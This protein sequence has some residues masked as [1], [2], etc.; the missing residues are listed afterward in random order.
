MKK[1]F[2][3]SGI[4]LGIIILLVV[5]G[6]FLATKFIDLNAFKPT[7]TAQVKKMT[8]RTLTISGDIN[9]SLYPVLGID[10]KDATLSNLPAFGD[11]P[12]IKANDVRVGVRLIPLL[13]R[14]VEVERVVVNGLTINLI[15]NRQGAVNW[16]MPKA[17]VEETK[18]VSDKDKQPLTQQVTALKLIDMKNVTINWQNL[19]TGQKSKVDQLSIYAKNIQSGEFFPIKLSLNVNSNKPNVIGNINLS[20]KCKVSTFRK[21]YQLRDFV[22]TTKLRGKDVPQGKL[23]ARLK[24][25]V[26]ITGDEFKVSKLN[27]VMN[28]DTV[29]GNLDA[30]GVNKIA[31]FDPQS[32]LRPLNIK[33][34]LQSKRLRLAGMNLTNAKF[35]L[36]GQ[37]GI[38]KAPFTAS[39]Y[40]GGLQVNTQINVQQAT[41]KIA[42]QYKYNN[43]NLSGWSNRATGKGSIWGNI[44]TRSFGGSKMMRTLNGTTSFKLSNGAIKGVDV[45]YMIYQGRRAFYAAVH[46]LQ[47]DKTGAD[48]MRRLAVMIPRKNTGQTRFSSISGTHRI[49]N[50]VARGSFSI[51]S[52][53]IKGGGSGT[54][55]MVKRYVYYR[56]NVSLK[57]DLSDWQVPI[58]LSGPFGNV[59]ASLDKA[60]IGKLVQQMAA[61]YMKKYL[62]Q[63]ILKQQ[64]KKLPIKLPVK[65]PKL[66]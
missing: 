12:F 57:G 65:L 47:L 66:F 61:E 52:P 29:T 55:N 35:N 63:K 26:V 44:T 41:P 38:I 14:K 24:S 25:D 8:G 16:Q 17:K 19:R 45:A 58:L 31:A 54:V 27:L 40:G 3:I 4:V 42:L 34:S 9:W 18:P 48:D 53:D 1:L 39:M 28:K 10:L 51:A 33:G 46:L 62:Q 49:T 50:G 11:K 5:I 20:G 30:T 21:Q 23:N 43:F 37:N 56:L 7:I 36:Q 59:K 60:A 2:K 13:F 6:G 15:K 32:V 22:L 64:I